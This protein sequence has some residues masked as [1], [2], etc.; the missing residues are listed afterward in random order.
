MSGTDKDESVPAPTRFVDR[1]SPARYR[2]FMESKLAK[3][4][5]E[6]LIEAARELTAEQRLAAF[7]EHSRLMTQLYLAG[8]QLRAIESP[9][10]IREPS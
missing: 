2:D 10:G 7:A 1:D 9:R 3:Y 8:E 6:T 4:A 5:Q